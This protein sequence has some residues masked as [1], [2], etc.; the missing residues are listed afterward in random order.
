MSK[1]TIKEIKEYIQSR[2]SLTDEE[3]ESFKQDPRQGVQ[4]LVTQY[5]MQ[6]EKLKK[7][8]SEHHERCKYEIAL[9]SKGLTRV[10]GIDEVGRGPLAGPVVCA[11]VILPENLDHFIGINDS[12]SLNHQKRLLFAELIKEKALAY[13]IIEIDNWTIDKDNVLEATKLGMLK[14]V[15]NLPVK[16]QHLLIDALNI[17][18]DI[19]Q[20]SVVKGDQRSIS[21]AAASI[22]AKVYRD[23]LM[24]RYHETYPEFDFIHNMGYGTKAHL[25]GLKEFGYTPIHRQ[26]FAP[27]KNT[28]F[29]YNK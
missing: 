18:V 25:D 20:T 7:L 4:K 15:N 16:P 21:I 12:K 10:A 19:P 2:K 24:I 6:Q 28:L 22:L 5:Y 29:P 3:L 13:S 8:M 27:V 1:R 26:S 9:H 23:E 14:S 11:S 17:N